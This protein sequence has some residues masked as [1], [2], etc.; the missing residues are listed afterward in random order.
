MTN[1]QIIMNCLKYF[2]P[3]TRNIF[4]DKKS[5]FH[6]YFE[7]FRKDSEPANESLQTRRKPSSNWCVSDIV[8]DIQGGSGD[9]FKPAESEGVVAQAKGE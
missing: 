4:A 8:Q 2:C 9:R 5:V 6:K 7:S 1:L 3:P